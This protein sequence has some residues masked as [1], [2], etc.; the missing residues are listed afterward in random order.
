MDGSNH[1]ATLDGQRIHGTF[2][3]QSAL[4]KHAVVV[5]ASCTVVPP[6]SDLIHLSPLGMGRIALVS[7]NN[8]LTIRSPSATTGCGMQT[9]AGAVLNG[10]L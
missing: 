1:N 2:F 4:A 10:D 5:E 9:G 8:M 3:G 7:E 6:E